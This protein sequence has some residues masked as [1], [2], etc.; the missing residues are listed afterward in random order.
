M[1]DTVVMATHADT[2]LGLLADADDA[3]RE[4]LSGFTYS[5]NRAVLHTDVGVLPAN[6]R[7]WAAWN[8]DLTDC[9]DISAPVSMT[10]DVTRLQDL[11]GDGRFCVTLNGSET[12]RSNVLADLTY[13]HPVLDRRAVA[14]QAR[15]RALNGRRHTYFCGAHLRYGFH[16]DGIVSALDVAAHFGAAL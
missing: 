3:E 12:P 8:C 5:V 9:R 1:V 13:T 10:Y 15:V 14:A 2:A 4:A 7:A 11:G 6:R 16:E